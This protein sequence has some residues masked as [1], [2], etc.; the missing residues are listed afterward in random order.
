MT[1]TILLLLAGLAL[2]LLGGE[3]L[4]RGASRLAERFG[5]SPMLVGLVIVGLGTSTPELAASV[6]A[7]LAGSPGIAIGNIVGSNLANILLIL[8]TAALI[9]PIAVGANALWRDGMVGVGGVLLLLLAGSTTG[10]SQLAGG[11]FLLI[12]AAY[13]A[14][15]YRQETASAGAS[16]AGQ[17]T[18]AAEHADPGLHPE[19]SGT[20]GIAVPIL[21]FVVGT[22]IIVAGGYILVDAA[23][24]MAA[25]LGVS[26]EVIGLTV[27]A[28][29]T[30]APELA[31]SA[32]AA[33]RK[34]SD[35]ALGNVLGSNIYNIFFIGGVTGLVAPGPI[36]GGIMT[37]DLWVL[38]AASIVAIIFAYTGGRLGRREGGL[39]VVGY[40]AFLAVTAGLV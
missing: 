33:F 40:V 23:I 25:R 28:A 17:R 6:Q 4:V 26:D 11:A 8:G 39:L 3:L 15:A 20:A 31:T 27:V 18:A 36:P 1:T 38:L 14:L 29:G 37:V 9:A 35:I 30:S 32:I 10:L 12:L 19:G 13:L 34:E 2:L 24:D 21:L 22:A 16:A 7:S 5:L